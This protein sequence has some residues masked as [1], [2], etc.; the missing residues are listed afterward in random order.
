M[1]KSL[2]KLTFEKTRDMT[3]I[4]SPDGKRI[5][6]WA[7]TSGASP[8]GVFV[9]AADG[10]GEAEKLISVEEGRQLH[11]GSWSNDGKK[12]LLQEMVTWTNMELCELPLEGDHTLKRLLQTEYVE[13]L[14][15]ISPDG[16]YIAYASNESG[17]DE[18]YVRPFP[19]VDKG[20]WQ[21]STSGGNSPVWSPDMRELFYL[22]ED[23]FAMAVA[24]ETEP[25][26]RF[27]TPE[28][29]FKNTNLGFGMY[30]GIP[31]DMHPDG[32][33]FLMMKQSEA[34]S[35]EQQRP[36]PKIIVVLNWDEE[37]RQ[38]VSLK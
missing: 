33:R 31:W 16:R 25:T 9:K 5:A 18:V 34:A 17:R 26:V 1:R 35:S 24:L 21:V 12:L 15:E 7:D 30:T 37:L 3:P 2:S 23:K 38:R 13:A 27:G 11:L 6:Y 8:N 32:K 36:K 22:S 10:T 4:W 29:L 20:K 19:E 14:P 28:V